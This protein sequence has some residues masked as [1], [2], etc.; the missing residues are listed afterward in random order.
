MMAT[1]TGAAG[2]V[3]SVMTAWNISAAVTTSCR[4]TPAGVGSAT[5]P[6]TNVTRWPAAAAA[7]AMANPIFPDERLEMNRTGSMA[8]R[9]GPAVMRKCSDDSMKGVRPRPGRRLG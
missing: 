5:G 2:S 7:R 8:S 3:I 1:S 9:V 4:V 6:A